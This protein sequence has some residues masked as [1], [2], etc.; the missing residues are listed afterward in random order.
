M[1]INVPSSNGEIYHFGTVP[2]KR[3][4]TQDFPLKFR[5]ADILRKLYENK[6][7]V[8]NKSYIIILISLLIISVVLGYIANVRERNQ[9][10]QKYYNS[11]TQPNR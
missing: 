7:L 2:Y 8:I 6:F 9:F 10:N 3:I 5:D 11:Q 4:D 1:V